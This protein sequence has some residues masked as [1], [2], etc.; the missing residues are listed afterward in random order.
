[1]DLVQTFPLRVSFTI[2]ENLIP[3]VH[4][5]DTIY[6]TNSTYPDKKLR[7]TIDYISPIVDKQ[8]RSLLVR[9]KLNSNDRYLKANQY[10]QV[11]IPT[12]QKESALNVRE[13]SLY[14]NQNQEY[15]YLAKESDEEG[16]YTAERK[17]VTT[18]IRENGKVEI[19]EGVKEG[20]LVIY[21][22][23]YSIYPGAKLVDVTKQPLNK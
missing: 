7:A 18:G 19:I 21:A 10:A 14:L 1:M 17:A 13:E 2:P 4:R 12:I 15:L 8:N 16:F 22:G 6:V 5:Y 3:Y 11:T 9:A 23:L 20:E